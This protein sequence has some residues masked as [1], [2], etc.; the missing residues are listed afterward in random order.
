VPVTARAPG[1][2]G[3]SHRQRPLV[4]RLGAIGLR[5][6]SRAAHA[7]A[8]LQAEL[9]QRAGYIAILIS[10]LV[11]DRHELRLVTLA[12]TVIGVCFSGLTY[13]DVFTLK[14]SARSAGPAR[15]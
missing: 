8:T 2:R 4:N 3:Q 7:T 6:S 1:P 5:A 14:A 11:P 10:L 9:G 13:R 15:C 12:M